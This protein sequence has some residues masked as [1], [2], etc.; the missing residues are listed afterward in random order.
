MRRG[1]VRRN[2]QNRDKSSDASWTRCPRQVRVR[3][4]DPIFF[5]CAL[6]AGRRHKSAAGASRHDRN[7][8]GEQEARWRQRR[9]RGPRRWGHGTRPPQVSGRRSRVGWRSPE[10][11]RPFPRC[12]KGPTAAA[13][14]VAQR[15]LPA[16]RPGVGE[17][18]CSAP[19]DV[20]PCNGGTEREAQPAP[21][22]PDGSRAREHSRQGWEGS[23]GTWGRGRSG[24]VSRAG[25][26][27]DC[28][29]SHCGTA[30]GWGEAR[31][32]PVHLCGTVIVSLRVRLPFSFFDFVVFQQVLPQSQ[33]LEAPS[34]P[35]Q[36][37]QGEGARDVVRGSR[38]RRR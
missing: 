22:R 13:A 15:A 26:S 35:R 6:S 36:M 37:A 25:N 3:C 17:S 5:L 7:V 4:A 29:R 8:R 16:D 23:A 32:A 10:W 38:R 24:A 14:A 2:D 21:G 11:G 30:Q 18:G 12:R 27:R 19:R 33:S 9:G 28:C 31:C 1:A 34:Q 20:D